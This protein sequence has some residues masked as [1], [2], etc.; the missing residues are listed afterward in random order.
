M[1]NTS[2]QGVKGTY[3]L[4]LLELQVSKYWRAQRRSFNRVVLGEPH[5]II[6][7]IEM[8]QTWELDVSHRLADSLQLGVLGCARRALSHV[9]LED[10]AKTQGTAASTKSGITGL[11]IVDLSGLDPKT[12]MS[13][14]GKSTVVDGKGKENAKLN[15]I[16]FGKTNLRTLGGRAV[17]IRNVHEK[18]KKGKLPPLPPSNADV[19][20]MC[21][22]WH[23]KGIC[24]RDFPRSANHGASYLVED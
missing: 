19:H 8:G 15:N 23:I 20:P 11:T 4:Q 21:L 10:D 18:I 7:M 22:A 9:D 5:E 3:H 24:N 12:P 2:R 16:L 13:A 1:T 6:D 17:K 14:S